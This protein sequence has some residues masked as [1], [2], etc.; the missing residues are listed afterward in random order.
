MPS[1]PSWVDEMRAV[2]A[3]VYAAVATT[4]TPRMD[5]VLQPLTS[6][7]DHSKLWF[8]I[9]AAAALLGAPAGSAARWRVSSRSASR[10][11]R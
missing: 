6:A 10:R 1:T 7:A 3:S 4:P 8:G 5:A 11:P 9:A 2:D